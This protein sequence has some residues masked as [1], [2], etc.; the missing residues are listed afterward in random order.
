MHLE[1]GMKILPCK[2]CCKK[3]AAYASGNGWGDY[4]VVCRNCK[5]TVSKTGIVG[6]N[7]STR[8]REA[9]V[10]IWNQLMKTS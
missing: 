5:V 3:P 10:K 1:D 9:T 6:E 8:R 2:L 4:V 7:W